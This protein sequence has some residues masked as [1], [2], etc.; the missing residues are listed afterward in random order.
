MCLEYRTKITIREYI[1][2]CS[3]K[4][5]KTNIECIK[6]INQCQ[7]S[8]VRKGNNYINNTAVSNGNI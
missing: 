7:N 3:A 6:A 5:F 1:K 4:L 2:R 8:A